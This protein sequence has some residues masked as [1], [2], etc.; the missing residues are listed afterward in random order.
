MQRAAMVRRVVFRLCV[1]NLWADL[2]SSRP[3]SM[4]NSCSHTVP[5][6]AAIPVSAHRWDR[7]DQL[8]RNPSAIPQ[9]WD[10]RASIQGVAQSTPDSP[11]PSA[12]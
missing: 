11:S 6:E 7:S 2:S 5:S 8:G 3:V 10:E 12:T 4:R 9:C 1:P